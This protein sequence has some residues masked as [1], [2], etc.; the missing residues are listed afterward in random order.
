V[1]APRI[2]GVVSFLITATEE[3]FDKRTLLGE[4]ERGAIEKKGYGWQTY[5]GFSIE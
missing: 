1:H 4:P 5:S 3:S 2:K